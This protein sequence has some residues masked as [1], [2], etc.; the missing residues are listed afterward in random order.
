VP[1]AGVFAERAADVVADQIIAEVQGRDDTAAYD[2]WGACYIESA[3]DRVAKVEITF[4]TPDGPQGG[5][6]TPPS[7]E[8]VHE[9]D[10]FGSS[11]I[12]RWFGSAAAHP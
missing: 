4:I 5:P 12:E 9:K 10:V 7:A 8:L 2:G 6:F 11:R 3:A 1:R